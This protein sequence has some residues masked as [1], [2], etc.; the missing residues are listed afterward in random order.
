MPNV[1]TGLSPRSLFA[2]RGHR[3]RQCGTRIDDRERYW[4][5]DEC[6]DYWVDDSL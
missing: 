6:E 5:S 2:R 4:C 1:L 3:C